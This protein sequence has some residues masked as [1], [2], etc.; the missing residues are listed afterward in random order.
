LY[1]QKQLT[2]DHCIFRPQIFYQEISSWHACERSLDFKVD[3]TRGISRAKYITE[4][5]LENGPE[6]RLKSA[7]L[8]A[9]KCVSSDLVKS[10]VSVVAKKLLAAASWGNSELLGYILRSCYC[11]VE[12]A[13]PSMLEAS[14]G[15]FHSC[16]QILL[17]AGVP[18]A[19]IDPQSAKTALHAACESGQEEIAALLI[20]K[21]ESLQQVYTKCNFGVDRYFTAFDI[22]R[23]NDMHGVAKRLEAKAASIFCEA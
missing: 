3:V 17:D 5:D 18:A 9:T 15:G 12:C 20:S 2:E 22:L 23:S 6:E 13:L 4:I 16:V 14:R 7:I 1:V 19:S 10:D 21:M 8:N 11:S